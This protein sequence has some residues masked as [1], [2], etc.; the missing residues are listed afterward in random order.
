MLIV[1][2]AQLQ[3]LAA[4]LALARTSGGGLTTLPLDEAVLAGRLQRAEH[5]RHHLHHNGSGLILLVLEDTRTHQLIGVSGIETAV[6]LD[7]PWYTYSVGLIVHAS[8][9][10]GIYH[11]FP[12]L[13]L[14]N[15]HTG[16]SELCSLY[17][18]PEYRRHQAG[19]LLSKAR[20]L[21][22]AQHRALFADKIIAEL[23]GV[24]DDQG[25]SPF[26]EGLGRH[27]FDMDF[28]TADYLSAVS[29]KQFIAELM[30]RYPFYTHLLPPTAQAVIGCEHRDTSPAR[31]ML[32]QEGFRYEGHVDIF[33]AGPTVE[34]YV[35]QIRA[36]R[37]SRLRL[38]SQVP[39]LASLPRP[40]PWLASNCSRSEFRCTLLAPA[41][42]PRYPYQQ[43]ELWAALKLAATEPARMVP[44][45]PDPPHV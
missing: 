39:E 10:L 29:N 31:H 40:Q 3:D 24:I 25:Q 1:R 20:F 30:P 35:D 45:Y 22:I 42:N 21:Y 14:S 41:A 26:W 37:R 43:P 13:F 8:T 28:S 9:E 36:V 4:L 44:L 17:L 12:T 5:S 18:H 33:D 2:M 34:T 11:R 7:Q 16:C 23:R 6:G 38:P 27:F 19:A 15:D 32:E